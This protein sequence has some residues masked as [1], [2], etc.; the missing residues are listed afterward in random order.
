M[1]NSYNHLNL[2]SKLVTAQSDVYM[3]LTDALNSNDIAAARYWARQLNQLSQRCID[4]IRV[5]TELLHRTNQNNLVLNN[6]LNHHA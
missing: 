2:P 3:N 5:K 6:E 1:H 4:V